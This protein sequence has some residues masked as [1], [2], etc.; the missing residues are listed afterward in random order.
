MTCQPRG[1]YVLPLC[2]LSAGRRV[3]PPDFPAASPAQSGLR[4]LRPHS[5]KN[6]NNRDINVIYFHKQLLSVFI[7]NYK[8][9]FHCVIPGVEP[10]SHTLTSSWSPGLHYILPSACPT[11][12]TLPPWLPKTD[13]VQ[14][15]DITVKLL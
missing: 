12:P 11:G 3:E 15:T 13:P 8:L 7:Q 4:L 10:Q 14:A 2:E 6:R 1:S 5:E 9:T